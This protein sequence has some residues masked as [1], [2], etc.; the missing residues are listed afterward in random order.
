MRRERVKAAL[1]AGQDAAAVLLAEPHR[2][3]GGS[4]T[5][6]GY[7]GKAGRGGVPGGLGACCWRGANCLPGNRLLGDPPSMTWRM[8]AAGA[9]V[10]P[11]PAGLVAA[12]LAAAGNFDGVYESVVA[13]AAAKA[14]L[15]FRRRCCK[16]VQLR[17]HRRVDIRPVGAGEAGGRVSAHLH[18]C[19]VRG[20]EAQRGQYVSSAG[21]PAAEGHGGGE[22]ELGPGDG[23]SSRRVTLGNILAA[24][25]WAWSTGRYICEGAAEASIGGHPAFVRLRVSS[26]TGKLCSISGGS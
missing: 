24:V 13:T 9:S 14:G 25:W 6:R 12:S 5:L 11:T 19:A 23:K 8:P 16:S 1:P 4:A 21:D 2:S 26:G 10:R 18:L 7:G 15:L 17:V 20:L 22:A 3:G